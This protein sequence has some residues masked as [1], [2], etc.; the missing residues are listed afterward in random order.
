MVAPVRHVTVEHTTTYQQDYA[1]I[2][3]RC[4]CGEEC[5]LD[6]RQPVLQMM[7][8]FHQLHEGCGS[9]VRYKALQEKLDAF[10]ARARDIPLRCD[11][12]QERIRS[13]EDFLSH[14]CPP[15]LVGIDVQVAK[16]TV[17][18]DAD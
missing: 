2:T 11:R 7:R 12:C 16:T 13:V 3:L 4:W 18:G 15:I 5:H 8:E 17:V 14:Q 9:S 6:P 1:A 10:N